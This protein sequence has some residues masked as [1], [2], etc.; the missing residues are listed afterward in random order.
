VD[1][2][3][4]YHTIPF[5]AFWFGRSK[6]AKKTC[7]AIIFNS[8]WQK[9]R[10]K[11]D[12]SFNSLQYSLAETKKKRRSVLQ[13]CS[14]A[15]AMKKKRPVL[16]SSSMLFGRSKEEKKTCPAI[17]FNALW[18]NQRRTVLQ[19]FLMLFGRSKKEKK[20]IIFNALW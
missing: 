15:E 9:H 13:L 7:P 20:T 8:L 19:S 2:K 14:L 3:K 16:P 12:L 6:E 10:S 18:Q 5:D 1:T 17:F 11:E 4:I